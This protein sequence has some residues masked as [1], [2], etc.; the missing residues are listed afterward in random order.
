MK[1]NTTTI[2]IYKKTKERLDKLKVHR[3]ESYE[4]IVE[5][6]LDILNMCRASPE[7]ARRRL[8]LMEKEIRRAKASKQEIGY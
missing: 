8:I 3:R 4:E 1:E 7:R 5:K 2:K 6:M